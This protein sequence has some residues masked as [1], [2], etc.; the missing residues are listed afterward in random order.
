MKFVRPYR[1]NLAH[2]G[3]YSVVIDVNG[4]I[5]AQGTHETCRQVVAGELGMM[6][7]PGDLFNENAI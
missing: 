4:K 7:W 5:V 6:V 1:I 2:D 3:Y